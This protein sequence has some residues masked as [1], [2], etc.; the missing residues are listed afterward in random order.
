MRGEIVDIPAGKPYGFM[1]C[2]GV[3]GQVFV[4]LDKV[5]QAGLEPRVGLELDVEIKESPRGPRVVR[6]HRVTGAPAVSPRQPSS[7][8]AE[9]RTESDYRF[10]NPYNFVSYLD[11]ATAETP[12]PSDSPMARALQKAGL[13][14][15]ASQAAN[16]MGR[17]EPPPHD[18]FLAL[19]GEIAC[20]L[21]TRAPLFV[22]DSEGVGGDKHKSYRFFS[23]N[24]QE[25]IPG[26][27]LRGMVRSAFEAATNSCFCVFDG[28]RTLSRR[29]TPQ[30]SLPLVPARVEKVD[31]DLAVRLL[32]GAAA[33]HT[34]DDGQDVQK[35]AWV[36]RYQPIRSSAAPTAA[37]GQAT[38]GY[39]NRTA[40][41]T[42]EHG[43][44]YY[45]VMELCTHSSKRKICFYNV[46]SLH[47]SDDGV[48]LKSNQIGAWGWLCI[49]NQNIETKHDERFFFAEAN[50]PLI[51]LTRAVLDHYQSLVAEAQERLAPQIS[52]RQP[53][54]PAAP[55]H[56]KKRP[57]FSRHVLQAWSELKE[58]DLVYVKL[59]SGR[60]D[61]VELVAPVMVPRTRYSQPIGA[62]L[63]EH[64]RP[65]RHYDQLCPACRTF[66][67]V[68]PGD[69]EPGPGTHAHRTA[70]AG[71]IAFTH[72]TLQQRGGTPMGPTRLAV[73]SAPK[74]TTVSFYLKRKGKAG[75]EPPDSSGYTP[76]NQLRG[77]KFY[78][79]HRT[80]ARH[81]YERSNNIADDQNRTVRGALPAGSQFSF[82]VTFENLAP[83]ELGALLWSLEAGGG[84]HKLGYARP[85]GFGSVQV[86]VDS[87]RVLNARARYSAWGS[88]GMS[89]AAKEVRAAWAGAFQ[90]A[91][92]EQYGAPFADLAN[93]R[94]LEAL[95]KPPASSSL[96]VHYP[97]SSIEP[98][99]DGK[100]F[101]WFM[102]NKRLK[103]SFT[104][105]TPTADSGL[106]ILTRD[107]R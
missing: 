107:R 57:A 43:K 105:G 13:G 20:T 71:R 36:K 67:W 45:A 60:Q 15:T 83:A 54:D 70:Y 51:P 102:A 48:V 76:Q 90:E 29:M 81:E 49:N 23:V 47:E 38:T 2:T 18:R 99:A 94:D 91:M 63:P 75:V 6:V 96:P 87:L 40:L 61:E 59:A 8:P 74:P 95:L 19:S 104:L 12:A 7:V 25:A 26:S 78:L 44:R 28:E 68:L 21:T 4:Y 93:I 55:D 30:E 100:N 31:G 9:G 72:A 64:L 16:V 24:G 84:W 88:G 85:L 35:A 79:H 3:Q 53:S 80:V 27:S 106:P 92:A 14:V 46:V 52:E 22:S 50:L 32:P 101:E 89:S 39:G 73:L 10:R 62:L 42:G 82:T 66:G 97:R 5:K 58:G 65:C 11:E 17:C 86:S 37:P 33:N 98:S 69:P 34:P 1:E 41:L 77:R 103:N 56:A